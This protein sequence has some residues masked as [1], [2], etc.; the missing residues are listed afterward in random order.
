MLNKINSH[1]CERVGVL[2]SSV[3]MC[4]YAVF[5]RELLGSITQESYLPVSGS[6]KEE[7][8]GRH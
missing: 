3:T 5:R 1:A 6:S 7:L 8:G 2:L 4:R